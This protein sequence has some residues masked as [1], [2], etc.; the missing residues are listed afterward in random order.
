MCSCLVY[1]RAL[2]VN[3]LKRLPYGVHLSV[4]LSSCQC[5]EPMNICALLYKCACVHAY[6]HAHHN[7]VAEKEKQA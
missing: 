6:T 7:F 2:F 3:M 4:M 5:P 1:K